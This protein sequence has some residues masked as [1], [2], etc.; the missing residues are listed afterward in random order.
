MSNTESESE[1]RLP[2]WRRVIIAGLYRFLDVVVRL[3]PGATAN[4][5]TWRKR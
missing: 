2:L 3:P 4:P 1:Y 5:L